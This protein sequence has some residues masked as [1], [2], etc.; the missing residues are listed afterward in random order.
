MRHALSV[1]ALAVASV[2]LMAGPAAGGVTGGCTATATIGS[3][4]YT[5]ANDTPGNPVVLPDQGNLTIHYV[6][7]TGKVIKQH[8]GYIAVLVGP[9][10][11]RVVDWSHPNRGGSKRDEGDYPLDAAFSR[12]LPFDLVGLYE[13]EGAH[14]GK[15]GRCD[16]TAMVLIEGNPLTTVPGGTAAALTVVT[17]IGMGLAAAGRKDL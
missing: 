9:G 2:L 10:S 13:I 12:F 15:G 11:V 5:P 8:S 6:G 16:G 1:A 7:T 4:T 17:G 3:K 14:A